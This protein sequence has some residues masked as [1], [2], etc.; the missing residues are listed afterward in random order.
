MK[1]NPFSVAQKYLSQPVIQ[2][3]REMEA[4]TIPN[5]DDPI[6]ACIMEEVCDENGKLRAILVYS[7]PL[8]DDLWMVFDR[9][10]EPEGDLAVYFSEEIP[11]LRGKTLEELRE[12][13]KVKLEFPGC[14][15]VQEAAEE[16][17]P[18]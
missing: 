8:H 12:I 17:K 7:I 15:I 1:D 11:L 5:E 3:R 6:E 16:L 18:E 4:Q 9:S 13:H 14:R 2:K 10:F